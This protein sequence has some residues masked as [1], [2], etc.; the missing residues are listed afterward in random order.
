MF[1]HGW[2]RFHDLDALFVIHGVASFMVL[3]NAK[4]EANTQG[5]TLVFLSMFFAN[6]VSILQELQ[7]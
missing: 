3:M 7:F 1:S 4:L 2:L 5:R 6:S